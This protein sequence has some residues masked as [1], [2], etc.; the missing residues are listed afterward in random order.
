MFDSERSIS[1]EIQYVMARRNRE[2]QMGN[3]LNRP[4]LLM[5][6][7]FVRNT[8]TADENLSLGTKY[9]E[10]KNADIAM[11][12]HEEMANRRGRRMCKKMAGKHYGGDAEGKRYLDYLNF[13]ACAPIQQFNL[14]PNADGTVKFR[15]ENLSKYSQV[16]IVGCDDSSTVQMEFSV[17]KLKEMAGV[18]TDSKSVP[19]IPM[20]DLS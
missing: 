4:S 7:E 12:E 5:N 10:A 14:K 11:R 15:L 6:R 19:K 2:N 13:L 17:E 9:A 3:S 20:R 16:S 18:V 1:D 8:Q